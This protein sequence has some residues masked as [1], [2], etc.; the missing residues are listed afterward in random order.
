MSSIY[1]PTGCDTLVPDHYCNTCES[2]EHGRV[3]SVA[4]VKRDFE[5][6]DI[7]NPNEWTV[8]IENK[9]IIIIPEVLGSFDGG[10]AVES[11]GYGDQQS[12]LNGF[13]FILTYKDPN[14]KDNA[15]FYNAL[16]Y[17]R[18][19]KVAYRTENLVHLSDNTVSVVPHNPVEEDLTTEVVWNV[20]VKFS[21][22][23]LPVPYT[24][25]EGIFQCFDY[26][27]S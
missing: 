16:K 26:V 5:F 20:E 17:S 15:D 7:T 13:D 2:T 22:G 21:Q 24:T 14:Y 12:K 1:Y 25:P 3:R 8:G 6:V 18:N 19:Y 4:F 27:Q 9:D 23:D 10:T 11:S